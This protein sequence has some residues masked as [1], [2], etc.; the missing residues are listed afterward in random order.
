MSMLCFLIMTIIR[1]SSDSENIDNEWIGFEVSLAFSMTVG[2]ASLAGVP[3]TVGFLG[4]FMV[5]NVAIQH[6]MS[7]G[8]WFVVVFAVLGATAGFIIISRS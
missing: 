2:I 8:Y 3:L 1:V 5:F 7:T 4:K 6:A